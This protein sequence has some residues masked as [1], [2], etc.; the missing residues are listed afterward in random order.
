MST[1]RF[2]LPADRPARWPWVVLLVAAILGAAAGAATV[3][4]LNRPVSVTVDGQVRTLPARSTVADLHKAKLLKAAPGALLSVKGEV[5]RP[6]GGKPPTVTRNGE[7]V[8]STQRL[9]QGDRI[10]SIV[11]A[12]VTERSVTATEAIP[13]KVENRGSG[14]VA[15]VVE[16][17]TAGVAEV[18]RGQVSRIKLS[19]KV[20]KTGKPMIVL[21]SRPTAG[22]KLVALTFD[23]GPVVGQT[24]KILDVLA[25]KQVKATFFMLGGRVKAQPALARRV[26]DEG[27]LVG[28]HS[29]GHK[30]LPKEKPAEIRRQIAGGASAIEQATGVDPVWFR[31]PYG[32]MSGKVW[33]ETRTLKLHIA[34]WDIDTSDWKKP[35]VPRLVRNAVKHVKPGAVILMHDGGVDRRQTIAALP[36]II[37][38]LRAQGYSFVTLEEL[39]AAK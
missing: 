1:S 29:L 6:T 24:D 22:D 9:R 15:K 11:G 18:T 35:G 39:A 36:Q 16:T 34:M 7:P 13:V 31:P 4:A 37:D 27:H 17:G 38:K 10:E 20:I 26:K 28:N 14:A 5:L 12:S 23:D 33:A 19:T 3:W 25:Q 30:N 21:R 8:P 32:A 2:E